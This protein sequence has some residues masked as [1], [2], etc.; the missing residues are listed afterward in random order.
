MANIKRLES[1]LHHALTEILREEMKDPDIGFITI[2][3]VDLTN[4]LSYLTIHYTVFE[5]AGT[6]RETAQKALERSHSFIR[7][8][9]AQRV[10]IRKMPQLRFRYDESLE[11]SERIREGLKKVMNDE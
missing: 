9:L 6:K 5:D 10:D 1:D 2:S 8:A 3:D 4:D 7:T 11:R